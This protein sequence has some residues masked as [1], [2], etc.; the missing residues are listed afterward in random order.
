M[1]KTAPKALH[2]NGAAADASFGS[3]AAVE[4]TGCRC[5]LNTVNGVLNSWGS[6]VGGTGAGASQN[7]PTCGRVPPQTMRAGLPL[8]ASISK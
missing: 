4:A 1:P 8:L 6:T 5:Q 3:A 7:L 2:L